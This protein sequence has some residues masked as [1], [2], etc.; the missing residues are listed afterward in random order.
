MHNGS[1]FIIMDELYSQS[2]KVTICLGKC[3]MTLFIH[4]HASAAASLKFEN[5]QVIR[6]TLYDTYTFISTL[7]LS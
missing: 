3:G 5:G 6:S 7:G 4:S 1:P 2:G